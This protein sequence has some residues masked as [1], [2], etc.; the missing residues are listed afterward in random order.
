M[1]VWLSIKCNLTKISKQNRLSEIRSTDPRNR[2]HLL[3]LQVALSTHWV[4]WHV[5]FFL[6]LLCISDLS[7]A[8]SVINVDIYVRHVHVYDALHFASILTP[9]ECIWHLFDLDAVIFSNEFVSDTMHRQ[10]KSHGNRRQRRVL[11]LSDLQPIPK[12]LSICE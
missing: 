12:Y 3:V 9:R 1:L 6:Q 2:N 11:A 7:C 10:A 4:V 5:N 8:Q